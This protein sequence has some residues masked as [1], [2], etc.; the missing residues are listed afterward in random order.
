M[1]ALG[2][3][4]LAIGAGLAMAGLIVIVAGDRMAAM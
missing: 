3:V 4:T 2:W 1:T